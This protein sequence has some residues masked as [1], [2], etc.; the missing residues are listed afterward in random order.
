MEIF[1]NP[2]FAAL[3][4]LVAFGGVTVILFK[5]LYAYLEER[6][7]ASEGARHE[8]DTLRHEIADRRAEIDKRLL[9]ARAEIAGLRAEIRAKAVASEAALLSA[10]RNAADAD[11]KV[12]VAR[13]ADERARA[14]SE[15]RAQASTL[16]RS[17]AGQVLGREV[18]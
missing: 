16:G 6:K 17:I 10:A 4:V 14:S 15:L 5:P 3:P 9:A 18:A 2:V 11:V 1:P 12:A 7:A 13:I 8:A